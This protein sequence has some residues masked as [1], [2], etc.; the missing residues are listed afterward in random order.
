MSIVLFSSAADIR[1]GGVFSSIAGGVVLGRVDSF[2][3]GNFEGLVLLLLLSASLSDNLRETGNFLAVGLPLDPPLFIYF[4][5]GDGEFLL[6]E[7]VRETVDLEAD[8]GVLSELLVDVFDDVRDR[9]LRLEATEPFGDFFRPFVGSLALNCDLPVPAAAAAGELPTPK[10]ALTL[11]VCL[12]TGLGMIPAESDGAG[13]E[14][15]A[16]RTLSAPP[17]N[18][19]MRSLIGVLL[20][21]V[22][23]GADI[24]VIAF[25][26]IKFY[27][28]QYFCINFHLTFTIIQSLLDN[29][30]F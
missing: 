7:P 27:R 10:L 23:R 6:M 11:K 28:R 29:N 5:V 26:K 13:F 9:S 24:S 25:F 2:T 22:M 30:L 17:P 1:R 19:L 18:I 4:F 12:S 14:F 8:V 3:W 16:G 21:L 20:E 15:G